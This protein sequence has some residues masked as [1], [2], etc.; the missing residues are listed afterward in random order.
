MPG[1]RLES[2]CCIRRQ[3]VTSRSPKPLSRS[4]WTHDRCAPGRPHTDGLTSRAHRSNSRPAVVPSSR[5]GFCGEQASVEAAS[6]TARS[7]EGR[8]WARATRHT[9]QNWQRTSQP[10]SS[11]AVQHLDRQ[12]HALGRQLWICRRRK[13]EEEASMELIVVGLL[14]MYCS[15]MIFPLMLKVFGFGFFADPVIK[16]INGLILWPF[17]A[18]YRIVSKRKGPMD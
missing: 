15:V 10:S 4:T 9:F 14:M 13:T 6:C 5:S 7:H 2:R 16:F 18:V 17:K 3:T 8:P 12:T 1:S 11:V